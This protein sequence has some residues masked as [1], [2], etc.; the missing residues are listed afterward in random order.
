[1]DVAST[2]TQAKGLSKKVRVMAVYGSESGNAKRGI[3]RLVKKW[4]SKPEC[5]FEVV[6]TMTGNELTKKL[7]GAGQASAKNLEFVA[8]TCDVLLVCTSSYG[9]GDPPSNMRELTKV[10][11]HEASMKSDGLTGVQH[12]V[13]G[14]GSSTYTTFQNIPRLTDKFLGECGS[15]RLVQRAEIDEHDP[16]PG[17]EADYKRWDAE[18]FAALQSLPPPSTPPACKWDQ[19]EGK[20]AIL[21]GDDDEDD[22]KIAG[23]PTV[24]AVS[25]VLIGALAFVV[26][27]VFHREPVE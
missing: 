14:F 24:Y 23:I 10:L 1:M 13:L 16:N 19:P 15:R 12:A 3:D 9:A 18:V 8:Q 5:N 2:P 17:D 4:T 11:M 6:A 25:S 21:D 22:S 26:W 27:Y 20:I 7:G